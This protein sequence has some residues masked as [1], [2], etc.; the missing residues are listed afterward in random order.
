CL[1][2]A[3]FSDHGAN[4]LGA[5]ALM[6]GLADGYFIIPYTLGG[7]LASGKLAAVNE[8]HQEFRAMETAAEQRL[9][10]LLSANGKRT[11]VEFHRALGRILWDKCGMARNAAGLKEALREIPRL[12]EEFWSDLKL[13]GDADGMNGAL[14]RAGRVADFL[15]LG[16]LLVRD[17]LNREESCGGHFREEHQTPEGEAKRNDADFSYVA[18]WEHAGEGKPQTLHKE[19]LAFEETHLTQR[20]YA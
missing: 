20:S 19:P 14:E 9:K 4:R 16:E 2:E 17:A 7:Y 12:R 13:S 3:N 6:Q 10:R 8:G 1:G 5:S 15:E 11:P 18:A